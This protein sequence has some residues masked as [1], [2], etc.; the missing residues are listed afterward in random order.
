MRIEKIGYTDLNGEERMENFYF[1]MS[2]ADLIKL[3]MC[4]EGGL[5][6]YIEKVINER[7]QQK[8]YELFEKIVDLSYGIKTLDGGFDKDPVH[9]KKFKSSEAYSEL[10]VK[11]MDADYAASFVADIMPKENA[12]PLDRNETAVEE[13]KRIAKEK[14]LA[15][16]QAAI[17]TM[18]V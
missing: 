1:H 5:D 15:Q 8:I 2:K 14:M 18:E 3:E 4:T 7:D 17:P 9:L 16:T 12:K 10:I 11:L 13:A 6:A